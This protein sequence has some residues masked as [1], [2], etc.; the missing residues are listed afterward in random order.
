MSD[1]LGDSRCFLG[2]LES[3]V[4]PLELGVRADSSNDERVGR[5]PSQSPGAKFDGS[6]AR[7]D[8]NPA[9]DRSDN[10]RDPEFSS[11]SRS[12]QYVSDRK[13]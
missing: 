13:P 12:F 9:L 8:S 10:R 11:F 1:N 4:A 7:K 5:N 6:L 3:Q 2:T